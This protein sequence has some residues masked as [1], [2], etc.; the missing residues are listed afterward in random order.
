MTEMP[1]PPERQDHP[2][3]VTKMKR[4]QP[5]FAGPRKVRKHLFKHGRHGEIGLNWRHWG[6]PF[7]FVLYLLA[8]PLILVF[9]AV[10]LIG[11]WVYAY[12]ARA[13][14]RRGERV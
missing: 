8:L 9:N 5:A 12:K 3:L 10:N 11:M 14:M 4:P 1:T 13:K 2:A 6:A 7:M